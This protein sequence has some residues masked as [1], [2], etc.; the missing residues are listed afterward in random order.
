[1][2][3]GPSVSKKGETIFFA[4]RIVS[5]FNLR[6][7]AVRRDCSDILMKL[8]LNLWLRNSHIISCILFFIYNVFG[9][10]KFN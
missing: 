9:N 4:L 10:L 6:I 5:F 3:I 8:I 1:M 7:S 2:V